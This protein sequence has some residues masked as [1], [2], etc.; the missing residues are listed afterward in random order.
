[1][2]TTRS[3]SAEKPLLS[4]VDLF[5]CSEETFINLAIIIQGSRLYGRLDFANSIILF[6]SVVFGQRQ[7]WPIYF[8]YY[9]LLITFLMLSFFAM[10]RIL[11][12]GLRITCPVKKYALPLEYIIFNNSPNAIYCSAGIEKCLRRKAWIDETAYE[13]TGTNDAAVEAPKRARINSVKQ[14][15]LLQTGCF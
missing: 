1:M 4:C 9:W 10:C 12:I 14:V 3:T 6:V 13:I 15:S 7:T 5:A 8:K 2:A 11:F